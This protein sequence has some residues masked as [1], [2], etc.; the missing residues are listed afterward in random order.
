[1][2]RDGL[3]LTHFPVC[4]SGAFMVIPFRKGG[5]MRVTHFLRCHRRPDGVKEEG[6]GRELCCPCF[7]H[8]TCLAEVTLTPGGHWPL[9]PQKGPGKKKKKAKKPSVE[10]CPQ[11]APGR[12]LSF[13]LRMLSEVDLRVRQHS[14][15][16]YLWSHFVSE[17]PI[18]VSPVC[19]SVLTLIF[20]SFSMCQSLP[21]LTTTLPGSDSVFSVLSFCLVSPWLWPASA[22]P[23]V[24]SPP[25]A[26][27]D[28]ERQPQHRA[29]GAGVRGA[30]CT[31]EWTASTGELG[32]AGLPPPPHQ[33]PCVSE[34]PASYGHRLSCG[35]LT[36]SRG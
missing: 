16:F 24:P 36:V 28:R 13:L 15:Y 19:H 32:P 20:I 22:S 5:K 33:A 3:P 23:S 9:S 6:Q 18:W 21:F 26:E 35:F 12:L 8:C 2:Y 30:M 25:L 14:L 34:P 31:W 11:N 29:V 27:Q 10:N 7:L 1:M 17:S 4:L